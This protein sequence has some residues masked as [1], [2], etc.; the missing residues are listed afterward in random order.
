M[1]D[2]MEFLAIST[3]AMIGVGVG[4]HLAQ[5]KCE[6]DL[7]AGKV[8]H[9]VWNMAGIPARL[10]KSALEHLLLLKAIHEVRGK[11][12][13]RILDLNLDLSDPE[14]RDLG[15]KVLEKMIRQTFPE[16]TPELDALKEEIFGVRKAKAEKLSPVDEAILEEDEVVID[17]PKPK[18][19]GKGKK[20]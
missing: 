7:E 16:P 20:A 13:A 12:Q 11:I 17:M 3:G 2:F 19:K 9:K 6:R 4:S 8:P 1:N 15:R 14:D 18:R 10:S 5:K